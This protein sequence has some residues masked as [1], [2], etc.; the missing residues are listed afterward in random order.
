MTTPTISKI[1]TNNNKSDISNEQIHLLTISSSPHIRH[2]RTVPEIM[3]W[4]IIALIP[5]FIASFLF[6]GL[7]AIFLT[8]VSVISAV[9]TESIIVRLMKKSSTTNDFSA[10]ITG[11]LLAFNVS[12]SLPWWM[13]VIGS[14]FSIA[15]AKMAFGGLGCNFVNPALAGRA[16]LMA[17]YPA[18]MTSWVAPDGIINGT[19]SGLNGVTGATPLAVFRNAAENGS[20]I[21]LNLQDALHSLFIGN[22]GGC[23]GETSVI[24]LLIGG[25]ILWSK[26]IIGL[27]IPLIYIS[28]VFILFWLSNGTKELFSYNSLIIPLFQILSGG[29]F[30]GAIFMATDMVTSPITP[31]GKIYFALGCGLLTFIIR[32][33]GGYPEG[34]SYSI[35]IM[36]LF[37]PLIERYTRPEIFGKVTK[38][39]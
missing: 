17:S 11:I 35:L 6:F 13:M 9:L 32:K 21:S 37:V 5:A 4:V 15:V 34:V 22:V 10:V 29:L 2:N 18:A 12:P 25:I 16:F 23:I 39:G 27:R 38:R 30:L 7:R 31:K 14:V 26:R 8:C 36:N 1:D 28:T 20:L 24:A 19:L 3:M 33:F